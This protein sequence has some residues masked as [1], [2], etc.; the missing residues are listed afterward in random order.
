M[1]CVS[2]SQEGAKGI[3]N[4]KTTPS[5]GDTTKKSTPSS[6][7]AG[8][9]LSPEDVNPRQRRPKSST[10]AP[11]KYGDI[12]RRRAVRLSPGANEPPLPHAAGQRDEDRRHCQ[13]AL[14]R[15]TSCAEA[16]PPPHTSHHRH[17]NQTKELHELR[18]H[19]PHRA[20]PK[21]ES[22]HC[23]QPSSPRR[24]LR[25]PPTA[26]E[27]ELRRMP[28]QGFEAEPSAAVARAPRF[29]RHAAPAATTA[30]K[31]PSAHRAAAPPS[32]TAPAPAAS[33][34]K[35][36]REDTAS[37]PRQRDKGQ[38]RVGLQEP[39]WARARAA[40]P[41]NAPLRST[42]TAPR[43]RP[44][45]APPRP[46]AA[47]PAPSHRPTPRPPHLV[48]PG[49]PLRPVT[50]EL[51]RLDQLPTLSAPATLPPRAATLLA[52]RP[53][54]SPS[55]AA[56]HGCRRPPAPAP[57]RRRPPRTLPV[58][59]RPAAW[60]SAARAAPPFPG[61]PPPSPRPSPAALLP[62]PSPFPGRPASAPA[63]QHTAPRHPSSLPQTRR[64]A[65]LLPQHT[66]R[67]L[68][69]QP[70]R[71]S[72]SSPHWPAPWRA[73]RHRREHPDVT[74]RDLDAIRSGHRH[75]HLHVR[76]RHAILSV[77]RG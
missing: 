48:T 55:P 23:C 70:C 49:G 5:R 40:K 7:P 66:A 14:R 4:F 41:R 27:R 33:P 39:I 21:A 1:P 68:L 60:P 30:A 34:V 59:G 35:A 61:R 54:L 58:A 52:P 47:P 71:P 57:P 75:R 26:T 67:P 63:P 38:A 36:G 74:T 45:R 11:K 69:P 50:R 28:T 37:A 13:P 3:T 17:H 51:V 18:C 9:R 65:P 8:S 2:R 32:S 43:P 12:R 46:P 22:H 6:D 76:H 42:T 10:T 56:P 77:R 15:H 16:A 53:H 25:A 72:L 20:G 44:G 19:H 31:P 62:S 64:S 29:S 24:A 73:Q